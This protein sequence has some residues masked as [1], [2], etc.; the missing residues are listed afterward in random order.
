LKHS[1]KN[2]GFSLIEVVVAS[3]LLGIILLA[4]AV[5]SR[6]GL[7][8]LETTNQETRIEDKVRHAAERLVKELEN[9]N[10]IVPDPDP[11]PVTDFV[12][13]GVDGVVAGVPQPTDPARMFWRYQAGELD[14]GLDN[15]GN[16]LIDEGEIVFTRDFGLAS[17]RSIVLA[18][19]VPELLE[20]ELPNGNDDNGNGLIDEPGFCVLKEE[21]LLVIRL[22][23][24]GRSPQGRLTTRTIETGL[25]LRD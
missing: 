20:G 25:R 8:M 3:S 24:Q 12:F 17:E 22:S 2:A 19:G 6:Q 14:D 15:N 10:A 4:G 16:G 18:R 9:T 1:A 23:V 5:V 7:Q 21:E 13:L 11:A